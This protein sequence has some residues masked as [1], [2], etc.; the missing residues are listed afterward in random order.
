MFSIGNVFFFFFFFFFSLLI[1]FQDLTW[2]YQTLSSSRSP[3]LFSTLVRD[4]LNRLGARIVRGE[5]VDALRDNGGLRAPDIDI[6][7]YEVSR[8]A[9]PSKLESSSPSR[10]DEADSLRR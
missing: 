4:L 5:I 3:S 7:E 8:S 6:D 10:A 1:V 2:S 9:E